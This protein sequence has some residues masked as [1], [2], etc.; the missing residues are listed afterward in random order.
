M[1]NRFLYLLLIVG[2]VLMS[3]CGSYSKE[4]TKMLRKAVGKDLKGYYPFSYPTNN[5]GIL[6]TFE[7]NLSPEYQLCAMLNCFDSLEILNS[8]EWLNLKGLA[9][10]GE[11]APISINERIQSSISVNAVLPKLWNTL[12]LKGGID[13]KHIKN[14]SLK[15]GRAYVRHLN[16]LRFNDLINSLPDDNLYKKQYLSGNLVIVVSDVVVTSMEVIVELEDSMKIALEAKFAPGTANSKFTDISLNGQ[17]ERI[18]SGKYAF[19]IN[20]PV[21]ILRLAKKQPQAGTLQESDNFEQWIYAKD[22][23]KSK[24]YIDFLLKME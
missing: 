19:K 12:D 9:D 10:I 16:R 23:I 24:E 15:M 5:F 8:S 21:I 1:K 20:Q 14:V 3:S 4:M 6:T 11:G 17:V 2:T 13:K 18:A 22:Y 7:Y